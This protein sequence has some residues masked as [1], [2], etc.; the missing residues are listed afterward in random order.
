MS[1]AC[2][3]STADASETGVDKTRNGESWP[4][5]R[6]HRGVT[7]ASP[8]PLRGIPQPSQP[9]ENLRLALE[10]HEAQSLRR[11]ARLLRVVCRPPAR[12]GNQ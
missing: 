1:R 9:R 2:R 12:L 4:A 3:R 10:L 8:S 7:F 6:A 5:G 11:A